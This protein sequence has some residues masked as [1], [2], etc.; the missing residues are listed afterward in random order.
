[1]DSNTSKRMLCTRADNGSLPLHLA[2]RYQ[3]PVGVV[4][5]LL[6]SAEGW[7]MLLEPYAYGQL[8]LHAACRKGAHP[9][10]IDLLLGHDKGK[11][12]VMREDHAE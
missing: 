10:V 6:G 8:P 7:C 4:M 2:V 12:T 3:A 5:L 9:D 11:Y 1:M